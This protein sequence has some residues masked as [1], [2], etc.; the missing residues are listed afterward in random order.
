[1][2]WLQQAKITMNRKY[3]FFFL[4]VI[5]LWLK[6]YIVYQLEFDLGID[7]SVQ[8]FL[9]FINPISSALFFLG[10][11]LF[12]SGKKRYWLI[13]AIDFVMSFLLYANVAYYRFFNDFI[14]LP[15]IMSSNSVGELGGSILALIQGTD[16][17]YFLDTIVLIALVIFGTVQKQSPIQKRKVGLVFASALLIF[18]TNLGIAQED[19]PQLLTRSF[20]RNYLVKYL[21]QYNYQVY[22]A[23]QTTKSFSQSAFADSNDL[24]DVKN[25][26]DENRTPPNKDLFGVAKDMNVVYISLE[27]FQN[28]VIDKKIKGEEVTPFLNQLAHG[29]NTFYFDNVFHQV[30]QGKTSDAEFMLA[31]GL[32]PLPSGAVSMQKAHNTFQA[33][34]AILNQRGY[35]TAA[36]HGN[37]KTFWNRDQL[38]KSFGIEKFF[39]SNYYNMSEENAINY[40]LKDK[41]FFKESM[42]YLNNLEQ[43][44]MAKF[45]TLSNH[46]PF[47]LDSGDVDFPSAGTDDGVVNGYFQTAHY[48]DESIEQFFSYLKESGLYENTMIVM[49]GDHYGISTNHNKAMK[50]VTG[51]EITPYKN[52]QLQRIPLFIHIPNV[53]GKEVH[54][55]GGQIDIRQTV[56]HLLGIKTDEYIS[57]GSDLLSPEH[58][59][60]VPFR[61][62]DFVTPEYTFVNG[63]CYSNSPAGKRVDKGKCEPYQQFI[64]KE[65]ELSDKVVYND[66]LRFYQPKGFKKVD[67]NDYNYVKD[68]RT[69]PSSIDVLKAPIKL[70]KPG[71]EDPQQQQEDSKE[72]NDQDQTT[73]DE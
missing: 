70:D 39:D 19:R 55:Y 61:N 8:S 35:T 41:P 50:Q 29:E 27:S 68:Q 44:F 22:D 45:L 17:F 51:E 5:L 16:V 65:L 30:G 53:K 37:T 2:N 56:L 72:T 49:Y 47:N 66:L 23:L 1:M 10:I 15:T 57:F 34:P 12:F 64:T 4:A 24:A 38:Y 69:N 7:N 9:L 62:G 67:P 46:F 73:N 33:Q 71:N 18:T 32:F 59:E 6:T 11:A 48:M 54:K 20:D 63:N 25:F 14:T 3:S 60:V 31:N 52:T 13:I 28:F 43:P 36:F 42:P 21:G 40:G 58:R 26:I